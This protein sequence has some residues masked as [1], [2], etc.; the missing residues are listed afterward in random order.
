MESE[1]RPSDR[2]HYVAQVGLKALGSRNPPINGSSSQSEATTAKKQVAA[3]EAQPG[4]H[5]PWSWWELGTGE[6]P[7]P[8]QVGRVGPPL[9]PAQLQP[10]SSRGPGNSPDLSL[11]A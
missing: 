6:I 10:P 2:Y 9:S 3:G 1:R 11:Q 4:L 7:A 8:F 5:T